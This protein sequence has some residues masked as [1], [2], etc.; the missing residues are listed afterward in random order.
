MP[1]APGSHQV[2]PKRDYRELSASERGYGW[3]WSKPEAGTAAQARERDEFQC[4]MCAASG[5][6]IDAV[7]SAASNGQKKNGEHRALYVDHIIPAHVIGD[8]RFHDLDNLQ[9]LCPVHHAEK[10]KDDVKKYGAAPR[11]RYGG[12][13]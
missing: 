2:R 4:V 10:T 9:T 1:S 13:Q 5:I 12:G 3:R 11:M 7:R 8:D 6:A